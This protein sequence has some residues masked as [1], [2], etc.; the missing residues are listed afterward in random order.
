MIGMHWNTIEKNIYIF[1]NT[2]PWC[3]CWIGI[4]WNSYRHIDLCVKT[5]QDAE[6]DWNTTKLL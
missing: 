5:I 1:S 3:V 4:Q 6:R 2:V